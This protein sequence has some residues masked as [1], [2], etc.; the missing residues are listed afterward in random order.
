FVGRINMWKSARTVKR[1]QLENLLT[2][3]DPCFTLSYPH[4]RDGRSRGFAYAK[5]KCNDK[6]D[7]AVRRLI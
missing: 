1:V 2:P 7:E 5:F 3:I 6:A 4:E